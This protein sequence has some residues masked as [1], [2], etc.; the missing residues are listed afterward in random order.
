M[1]Q[2][3]EETN[4]DLIVEIAKVTSERNCSRAGCVQC[5]IKCGSFR[6]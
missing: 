6:A 2:C 3:E 1:G 4:Y 5:I